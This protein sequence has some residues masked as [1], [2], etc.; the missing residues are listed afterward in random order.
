MRRKKYVTSTVEFQV[1]NCYFFRQSRSLQS[2]NNCISSYINILLF[3]IPRQSIYS[4]FLFSFSGHKYPPPPLLNLRA[5]SEGTAPSS[6]PGWGTEAPTIPP[7]RGPPLSASGRIQNPHHTDL[8]RHN[9]HYSKQPRRPKWFNLWR[10]SWRPGRNPF[11]FHR[12]HTPATPT[13]ANQPALNIRRGFVISFVNH[14]KFL[15]LHQIFERK[16]QHQ[17]KKE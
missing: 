3:S 4:I 6:S 5:V 16:N 15:A 12:D 17:K 2:L 10:P 7:Y 8:N 11:R 14:S 1:K 13:Q 9:V